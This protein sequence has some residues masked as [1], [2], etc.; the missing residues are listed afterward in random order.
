MRLFGAWTRIDWLVFKVETVHGFRQ[1]KNKSMVHCGLHLA[2]KK[3]P[4][5]V[6]FCIT[7]AC[8]LFLYLLQLFLKP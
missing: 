2:P 8:V 3:Q 1:E 4:P 7:G 5:L 6:V